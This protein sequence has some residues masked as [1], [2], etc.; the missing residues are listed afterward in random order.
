MRLPGKRCGASRAWCHCP[1]RAAARESGAPRPTRA[2]C[3][4]AVCATAAWCSQRAGGARSAALSSCGFWGSSGTTPRAC[5]STSWLAVCRW[6]TG[7]FNHF[8]YFLR[9]YPFFEKEGGKGSPLPPPTN[10]RRE[11]GKNLLKVF[12]DLQTKRSISHAYTQ[13]GESES[14][15][16]S[17]SGKA[18]QSPTR[19]GP[20][21]G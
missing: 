9:R 21:G 17:C 18:L 7:L 2:V 10:R 19:G 13:K 3:P 20:R 16:L 12:K 14:G 8:K 15:Y 5:L 11:G 1:S 6:H 4:R